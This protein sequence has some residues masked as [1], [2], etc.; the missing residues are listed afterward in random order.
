MSGGVLARVFSCVRSRREEEWSFESV[1][2]VSVAACG[3]HIILYIIGGI[4]P[5][6]GACGSL[7]RAGRIRGEKRVFPSGCRGK[8]GN[9]GELLSG[10]EM[11]PA[12]PFPGGTSR[13]FRLFLGLILALSAKVPG[14]TRILCITIR[15]GNPEDPAKIWLFRPDLGRS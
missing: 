11:A 9:W 2:E 14:R 7:R 8:P 15:A 4:W 10:S 5:N 1:S 3:R 6:M 12:G 13:R